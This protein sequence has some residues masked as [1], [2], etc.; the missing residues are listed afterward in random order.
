MMQLYINLIIFP[1]N[2]NFKLNRIRRLYQKNHSVVKRLSV[3]LLNPWDSKVH[4]S[5]L[6]QS[7]LMLQQTLL[8]VFLLRVFAVQDTLVVRKS[9]RLWTVV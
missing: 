3:L 6:F 9:T 7:P 1:S 2:G 5:V 4:P 8:Q